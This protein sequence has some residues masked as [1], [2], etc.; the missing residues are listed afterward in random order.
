L[1]EGLH[2]TA[3]RSGRALPG[4]ERGVDQERRE[5]A[6]CDVVGSEAQCFGVLGDGRDRRGP[7]R[8]SQFD[9][10]A[11]RRRGRGRRSIT[12]F[13]AEQVEPPGLPVRALVDINM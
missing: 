7:A 10:L 5:Y 12:T 2:G 3:T 11:G 1:A 8:S 9:R 6:V 4:A 13:S